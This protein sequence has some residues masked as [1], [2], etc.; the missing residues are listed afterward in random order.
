[1]REQI[2]SIIEMCPEYQ[3][4][5]NEDEPESEEVFE[6]EVYECITA[7]QEDEIKH[8]CKD[9]PD[10]LTDMLRRLKL[11]ELAY[12]RKSEYRQHIERLRKIV[13]LRRQSDSVNIE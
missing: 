5:L 4:L 7:E 6:P 1:M 9:Y 11:E 3:T 12:M 2:Q 8:L 10:M 13:N